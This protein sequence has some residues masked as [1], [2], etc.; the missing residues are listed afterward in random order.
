[1][2]GDGV[3]GNYALDPAGT[4][5]INWAG[6]GLGS[7]GLGASGQSTSTFILFTN[8]P[9]FSSGNINFIDDSTASGTAL[10]P[11]IPEPSSLMLLGTG[12]L[13]GAGML[14]RRRRLTA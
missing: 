5:T 8:A 13:S 6:G 14:M 10:V 3:T 12:L 2:S 7:A 4:V 9:E 1:V 11:S